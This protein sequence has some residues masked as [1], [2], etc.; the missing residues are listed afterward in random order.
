MEK[1]EREGERVT[2]K[3]EEDFELP[4]LATIRQGGQEAEGRRQEAGDRGRGQEIGLWQNCWTNNGS[5]NS[6][7]IICSTNTRAH[8]QPPH[9]PPLHDKQTRTRA[10]QGG[11]RRQTLRKHELCISK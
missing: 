4:A 5:G 1:R 6:N 7:F 2:Q 10:G 3:M 11:R 8:T 9:P